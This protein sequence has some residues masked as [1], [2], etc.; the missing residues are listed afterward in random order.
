MTNFFKD[1]PDID[2]HLT[3]GDWDEV[4]RLKEADFSD[5]G[6]YADAPFDAQDAIDGY[7]HVLDLVGEIAGEQIAPRSADV[8]EEGSVLEGGKVR[9]AAGIQAAIR[10]LSQADLM[11]ITLPRRYGGLNMP[12]FV[13]NLAIEMI[14]QGD[15]SLM[16]IFGLQDIAE[17]IYEFAS[18]E[19]KDH[20]LPKF[21]NG[22]VTGAMVLTEPD[23]G[24]DLQAVALR[25]HEDTENSCWR[26]N[27]VKRFISN[28][29]GH[30]LLVLARSEPGSATARGLSLLIC[31]QGPTVKIRRLEK[32]LGIR[33]SPTC[34]IQFMNT[35]AQ[36]IGQRKRGLTQYVMALMNGAR[37]GIAGQGVGIAQAAYNA[38]MSFAEA[39]EQFGKKIKDMPPVRNMLAEMK[40][41]IEAARALNMRTAVEVDLD[42][43]LG[44]QLESGKITERERLD[45]LKA[46][47]IHAK[48]CAAMLTPMSKLLA[49]EMC[50][51]VTTTA[52]QVHG[53]SGYMKDYPVERYFR[54]ARI[55]NIY[56]GTS[57]LQVV[58]A[59]LGVT[60]GTLMKF[61]SDLDKPVDGKV[62]PDLLDALRDHVKKMEKSIAEYN[63][64][65][66]AFRQLYARDL[67]DNAMETIVSYLFLNASRH[68][69]HKKVI[70]RR[71]VT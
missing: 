1:N 69:E 12:T 54:D 55:T 37:I 18:D 65:D 41:Q 27:G 63:Q 6:I 67:V 26:L 36:L 34:E 33:G 71:Y 40:T 59:I 70:A 7:R 9:Y 56:E 10:E 50:Q 57:E 30:V 14:S 47:H 21:C 17:T 28:G 62:D 38:A 20:Y 64:Q 53:G 19:I 29:C 44:D 35:P 5:A 23:A 3:H 58:A 48:R 45:E 68:T 52:I 25:A 46:R 4:I 39:R 8:D 11:G 43:Y 51:Y 32:K 61:L 22:E 24:S 31:E 66:E 2:F 15:A 49:T 42:R 13:Y 60:S 16:T